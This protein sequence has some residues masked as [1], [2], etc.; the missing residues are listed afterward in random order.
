[1]LVPEDWRFRARGIIRNHWTGREKKLRRYWE[2]SLH[3]FSHSQQQYHHGTK[4][5]RTTLSGP[6]TWQPTLSDIYNRTCRHTHRHFQRTTPYAHRRNC[7]ILINDMVQHQRQRSSDSSVRRIWWRM[8]NISTAYG[9]THRTEMPKHKS[10]D[11]AN[12]K[13]K[14]IWYYNNSFKMRLEYLELCRFYILTPGF[15]QTSKI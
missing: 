2:K 5:G 3:V 7:N 9:L 11:K 8:Y 14:W 6:R 4:D 12:E 15:T 13:S 1:M 10:H